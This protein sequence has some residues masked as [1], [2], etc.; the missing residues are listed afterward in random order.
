MLKA[1][2]GLQPE[3]FSTEISEISKESPI[4]V[5]QWSRETPIYI[6]T[7]ILYHL[8]TTQIYQTYATSQG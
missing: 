2:Q 8:K 5:V 6:H 4:E 7:H 1:A 3:E